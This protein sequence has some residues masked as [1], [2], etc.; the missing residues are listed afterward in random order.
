M[1]GPPQPECRESPAG[2][3][4]FVKTTMTFHSPGAM[5]ATGPH[6]EISLRLPWRKSKFSAAWA[7]HF[8]AKRSPGRGNAGLIQSFRSVLPR[9]EIPTDVKRL[10]ESPPRDNVP[11][12]SLSG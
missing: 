4:P 6:G 7:G 2:D 11:G 8:D 1:P 3:R 5:V 10:T 9:P 12:C